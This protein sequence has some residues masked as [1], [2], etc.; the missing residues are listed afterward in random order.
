MSEM[1]FLTREYRPLYYT[2]AEGSARGWLPWPRSLVTEAELQAVP[3][4][5]RTV[6]LHGVRCHA[7]AFSEPT[8]YEM[9]PGRRFHRW[10]SING[11]THHPDDM[12][13]GEAY[14]MAGIAA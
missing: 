4:W 8:L 2:E 13:V 12:T 14:Q 1:A 5:S 11:W 3:R 9:Y 10:D 6:L 7:L